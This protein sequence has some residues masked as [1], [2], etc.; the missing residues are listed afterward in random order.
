[1]VEVALY[2]D[3]SFRRPRYG[4]Y[5]FVQVN[6]DT[7]EKVLEGCG[8]VWGTTNNRMEIYAIF[9]GL[10]AIEEPSDVTVYTDSQYA[11]DALTI[12]YHGWV[13]KNWVN[14]FGEPVKNQDVIKQARAEMERHKSVRICWVRGHNGN[15]FNEHC[16]V[17]AQ[18]VTLAMVNGELKEPTT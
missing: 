2:T 6:P 7:E 13:K 15:T 16:D 5:A 14:M 4:S 17:L 3:G 1:M 12:W 10:E 8:P 11:R 9:K 18:E